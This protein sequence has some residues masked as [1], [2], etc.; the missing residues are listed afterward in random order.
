[1]VINGANLKFNFDT[2]NQG[3][4][5]LLTR[6]G[7]LKKQ[8]SMKKL[9]LIICLLAFSAVVFSGC[10]K[11]DNADEP[12][13]R[14]KT[15]KYTV[16]STGILATDNIDITFNGGSSNNAKTVLKVDGATQDNQQVVTLT[17][18]QITKSGGTVVESVV[19]LIVSGFNL[20]GFS[21]TAGHTFVVKVVPIVDGT[22][23]TTV[24]KT[25]TTEVFSQGYNY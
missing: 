8:I 18:A 10:K 2:D 23:V 1:M 22:P 9:S 13:I 16:T 6:V 17:R 4:R 14:G 5:K 12:D 19:P 24:S 3:C 25:F 7:L 20:S 21:G 15:F 11:K